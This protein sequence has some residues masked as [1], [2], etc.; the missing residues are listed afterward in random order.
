MVEDRDLAQELVGLA[1]LDQRGQ[2]GRVAADVDAAGPVAQDAA[3]PL[4]PL[5]GVGQGGGGPH[6]A[7]VGV[8][9]LLLGL[10]ELVLG[11][12]EGLVGPVEGGGQLLGVGLG[13]GQGG[14]HLLELGGDVG[15]LL[16]P[17]V[18]GSSNEAT[19]A[20]A[21]TT[22]SHRSTRARR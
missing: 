11:L 22:A 7:G 19:A 10:G 20:T 8:E 9:A 17:G 13:V 4:D 5:G 12:V 16:G 21:A 3:Q 15:P 14:P 2:P 18:L 1:A 6:P